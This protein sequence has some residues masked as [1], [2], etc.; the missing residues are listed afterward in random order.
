V[1]LSVGN[2]AADGD[3]VRGVSV[4]GIEDAVAASLHGLCAG[5]VDGG[6]QMV[7]EGVRIVGG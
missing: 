5:D 3:G 4:Q 6:V 2:V 7:F 1:R